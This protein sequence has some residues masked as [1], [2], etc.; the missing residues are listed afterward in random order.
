MPK[1][2]IVANDQPAFARPIAEGLRKLGHEVVVCRNVTEVF[3]AFATANGK[4]FDLIITDS[5]LAHG[6]EFTVQETN[7]YQE[8]GIALYRH[9]RK[10]QSPRPLFLF[11]ISE[12]H[13]MKELEA[14]RDPCLRVIDI[15]TD[16]MWKVVDAAAEFLNRQ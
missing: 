11:Y 7:G 3:E 1:R 5:R 4:K 8:T 14:L 15:R 10:S 9:M 13:L 2:I 16:P 12:G 6:D